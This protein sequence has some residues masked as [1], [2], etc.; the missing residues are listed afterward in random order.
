[1]NRLKESFVFNVG[2]FDHFQEGPVSCVRISPDEK[3]FAFS[4]ARG[5]SCV[6][7]HNGSSVNRRILS[8][9]HEGL[10]VTALQWNSSSTQLYVGDNTG[11]ISVIRVASYLVSSSIYSS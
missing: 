11:R 4:T 7:E 2:K 3:W 5:V 10:K 6:L 1:M 8:H 9:E